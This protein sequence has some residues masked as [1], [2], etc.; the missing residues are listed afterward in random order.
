MGE[1]VDLGG[2]TSVTG[3]SPGLT[4][5][6]TRPPGAVRLPGIIV[7]H[8][9]FG[10]EDITRRQADRLARLGYVVVAPDLFS[11]G[12]G[13]RCLRATFQALRRGEGRAFSDIAAARQWLL[14]RDDTTERVGVIGFCMGGGFALLL[15]GGGDFDVSAVNYGMLPSTPDVLAGA[16]PIVG[17]YGGRDRALA[18][19]AAKLEVQ[20]TGLGVEHDIKE[21]PHAGHAFLNDEETGPWYVRPILKILHAGPEPRSAADAWRR[22]EEFFSRHLAR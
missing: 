19:A 2:Q 13:R 20:L 18:G 6:T 3:C 9:A 16:C 4:A 5:Y 11:A 21:Y 10:L 14:D 8:E 22:I 17:S 1:M 7:I 15:A 12:G